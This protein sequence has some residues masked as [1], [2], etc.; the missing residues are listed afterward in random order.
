[1]RETR[2]LAAILIADVV[3]YGQFA[4]ADKDLTLACLRGLR[5]DLI[6]L[7]I[8]ARYGRI[9]KRTGDG[10]SLNSAA[11]YT[12]CAAR[13]KSRTSRPSATLVRKRA[14]VSNFASASHSSRKKA[15][16]CSAPPGS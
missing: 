7:A 16:V 13:S 12:P 4:G 5:S 14:N 15:A 9:V 11:S 3:A 8:G 6:D 2:K 1:M 10:G